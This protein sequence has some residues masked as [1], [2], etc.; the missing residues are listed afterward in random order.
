MTELITYRGGS[1][2]DFLRVLISNCNY[3]INDVGKI[4]NC[5]VFDYTRPIFELISSDELNSLVTKCN[6]LKS[7]NSNKRIDYITSHD[8]YAF[9][10]RY[11]SA[12]EF[13]S[14]VS[15]LEID[16]VLYICTTSEKSAKIKSINSLMKNQR[17]DFRSAID[18]FDKYGIHQLEHHRI[19]AK[20]YLDSKRDC[21]IMIELECIY[22]KEYLRNFLLE[23]YDEWSDTNFDTIYDN[24]MSKQPNLGDW[25]G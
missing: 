22:D 25:Y 2:G 23:N 4:I 5:D 3:E 1:C 7:K 16:R 6:K 14:F 10:D 20:N 11:D 15:S 24:Y 13:F 21:D 19:E 9:H 12:V 18:F 17:V 8:Y